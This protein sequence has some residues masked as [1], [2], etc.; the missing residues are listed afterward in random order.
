LAEREVMPNYALDID[1]G[2]P[3]AISGLTLKAAPKT[4]GEQW[5]TIRYERFIIKVGGPS[6]VY[7]LA[8]D[9]KVGMQVSYV[10]VHGNPAAVDGPVVWTASDATLATVTVEAADSTI[11]TVTPLGPVGQVQV[12]ATA[13]VD[14]GTGVK[15]LVTNADISLVAGEAVSG[16]IQPVGDPVPVA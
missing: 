8:V 4:T 5:L 6:V 14:L 9:H 3:I 1:F 12:T 11:C 16:T 7:T 15:Q 10:D 13:D 2:E